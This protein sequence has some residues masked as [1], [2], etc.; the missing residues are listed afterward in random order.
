VTVV[1]VGAHGLLG[2][3][4]VAELARRRLPHLTV[5]RADGHHAGDGSTAVDPVAGAREGE[6]RACGGLARDGR[7]AGRVTHID[8]RSDADVDRLCSLVR[9]ATVVYCAQ[10][11]GRA[12]AAADPDAARRVNV[13]APARLASAARRMIYL[14]SDY[15]FTTTGA[16][17]PDTPP[18]PTGA[19]AVSKAD[20]ERAVLAAGRHV[21]VVR[22]SGLFDEHTGP[23][24][25]FAALDSVTAADNRTTQLTYLPDL[26]TALLDVTTLL[27]LGGQTG[28]VH[29]VGPHPLSAYEFAQIASLR[30]GFDVRPVLSQP[31]EGV[32]LEPTPGLMIRPPAHVFLP[33]S[34][35]PPPH[36][37]APP[38]AP[39]T[40]LD[41]VGVVL[42]GRRH[43]EPDPE[44][45]AEQAAGPEAPLARLGADRIVAAYGPN[46]AV[47]PRLGRLTPGRTY[48]LAN[49]GPRETFERWVDRYGL[50][51]LFA[52][53]I[54]SERD[55]LTKAQEAFRA[56]VN[57][58]AGPHRVQ[59]VDDSPAIIA[60]AA[61]AGWDAVLTRRTGEGP[62]QE[63]TP[64]GPIR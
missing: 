27:D 10:V 8:L 5:A 36:H 40:V 26:V 57:A 30:W 18:D 62:I 53:T 45:W 22:T 56:R 49:N 16:K 37:E 29:A 3:R 50:D 35:L 21:V 54:N 23:L 31:R 25:D 4:L 55:G 6:V 58:L 60:E 15:V 17:H 34:L 2:T 7:T 1:V 41:T 28:I 48:V 13:T 33:N 20:G 38:A 63:Y 64:E 39:V 44:F 61:R 11:G 51:R 52:Y 59:L 32:V 46:P 24:G 19:Y 43:R 9:D 47:W 14:S 42:A 12:R